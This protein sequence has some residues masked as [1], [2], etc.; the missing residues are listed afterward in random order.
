MNALYFFLSGYIVLVMSCLNFTIIMNVLY[1][2]LYLLMEI[3][4][5]MWWSVLKYSGMKCLGAY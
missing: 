1:S 5:I 2:F 4:P 3:F